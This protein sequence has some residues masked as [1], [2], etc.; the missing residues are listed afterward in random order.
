MVKTKETTQ[1]TSTNNPLFS[2]LIKSTGDKVR[3]RGAT[4]LSDALKSNKALT[5]FNLNG[6]QKRNN[7]QMISINNPLFSVFINS[8]GNKI[9]ETG[10]TSLGDAL[11][12]NTTLTQLNLGSEHKETH[13]WHSSTV[14][15]FSSN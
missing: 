14:N 9:G 2:I 13:K 10:A 1:M 3:E 15:F 5:Q 8:T 7:T 6:E 4:S 12:S 11:K